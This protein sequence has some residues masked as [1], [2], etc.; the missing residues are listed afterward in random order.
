MNKFEILKTELGEKKNNKNKI[1]K[2]T[3]HSL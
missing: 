2:Q 3:H 1:V